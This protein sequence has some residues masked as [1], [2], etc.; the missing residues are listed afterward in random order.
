MQSL[1]ATSCPRPPD[2]LSW[3]STHLS[4][5][6]FGLAGPFDM[7]LLPLSTGFTILLFRCQHTMPFQRGVPC[8]SYQSQHP[9]S[10]TAFSSLPALIYSCC[11]LVDIG[12]PLARMWALPGG[13]HHL[14]LQLEARGATPSAHYSEETYSCIDGG[15][16]PTGDHRAGGELW[17]TPSPDSFLFPHASHLA[18]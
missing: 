2:H 13:Q 9:L 17:A 16:H 5:R 1:D 15:P 4:L 11:L 8:L 3:K 10:T 7:T 18:H 6:A 14:F 12:V